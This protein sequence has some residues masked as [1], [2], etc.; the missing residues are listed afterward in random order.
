MPRFVALLRGINVGGKNMLPMREL[1]ALFGDAGCKDVSSYIKSGNVA[2]SASRRVAKTVATAVEASI[3]KRFSLRVPVVLRSADEL[4]EVS[5][6]NPFLEAGAAPETLHVMFL[7]D[8]PDPK[9][10]AALDPRRSPPDE[11]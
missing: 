1:V 9:S 3:A 10:V 7:S 11:F 5:R 8:R 4:E 2:F 6:K